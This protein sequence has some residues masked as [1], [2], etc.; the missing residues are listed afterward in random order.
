MAITEIK[1]TDVSGT[2]G[3]DGR[4]ASCEWLVVS[5][6]LNDFSMSIAEQGMVKNMITGG[7]SVGWLEPGTPYH[8]GNDYWAKCYAG[9]VEVGDRR[10]IRGIGDFNI[11]GITF[12]KRNNDNPSILWRVKQKYSTNENQKLDE[13]GTSVNDPCTIRMSV[14]IEDIPFEFDMIDLTTPVVNSAGQK[15]NPPAARRR[16]ILVYSVTRREKWNPIQKAAVYSNTVNVDFYNDRIAGS[17]LMDSITCDYDGQAWKVTYNIKEK[18]EGWQAFLLD[19]GYYQRLPDGY[20]YPILQ[21][22]GTMVS[23]PAKLDGFG[24][25]LEDQSQPGEN[26]GPFHKYP[27]KIFSL[28]QLP[29]FFIIDSQ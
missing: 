28:L 14:E 26:V 5:D 6:N 15:F 27:A 17:L 24:Q 16:K 20:L 13:N 9:P 19:T 8:L 22:D 29:N 12:T 3:T 21:H 2:I 25:V 1:L 18:T 7:D 10:I 23:E 11:N 4:E